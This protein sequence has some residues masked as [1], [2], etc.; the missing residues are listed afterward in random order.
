MEKV[1]L[2]TVPFDV[3]FD[4]FVA[5]QQTIDNNRIDGYFCS[6]DKQYEEDLRRYLADKFAGLTVEDDLRIDVHLSSLQVSMFDNVP[7]GLIAHN[8]LFDFLSN[9]PQ[10]AMAMLATCTAGQQLRKDPLWK[11]CLVQWVRSKRSLRGDAECDAAVAALLHTSH[12][13]AM[14]ALWSDRLTWE[15][16]KRL[17]LD[18]SADEP[19]AAIGGSFALREYML[20]TP[21]LANRLRWRHDDIDVFFV[22]DESLNGSRPSF[23][24]LMSWIV[25]KC[26]T[27]VDTVRRELGMNLQRTH[28]D[29]LKRARPD[30]MQDQVWDSSIESHGESRIGP[31]EMEEGE[32]DV[33]VV[34]EARPVVTLQ[35][36][37]GRISFVMCPGARSVKEVVEN[38]DLT[39][40]GV[41]LAIK[42]QDNGS[43]SD[44]NSSSSSISDSSSSRAK[45]AALT[46]QLIAS[47]AARRDVEAGVI[48]V[49]GKGRFSYKR[50]RKYCARGFSLRTDTGMGLKENGPL[51]PRLFSPFLLNCIASTPLVLWLPNK[52]FGV[53]KVPLYCY[54]PELAGHNEVVTMQIAH[55]L[56]REIRNLRT[57]EELLE[58]FAS[59]D[60]MIGLVRYALAHH[61]IPQSVL[62]FAFLWRPQPAAPKPYTYVVAQHSR[63]IV[64]EII[65][66]VC[67]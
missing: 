52:A 33:Y 38:V 39:V 35:T 57:D 46:T 53:I 42:S 8:I 6:F 25:N 32:N 26:D 47:E 10:S 11:K 13:D 41:Y 28:G 66:H 43:S 30:Q 36:P 21:K 45:C 22:P 16:I 60:Q 17:P 7:R 15:L 31:Y 5:A 63:I 50:I 54:D 59:P 55:W 56:V 20:R 18:H 67:V 34:G 4:K 40:C 23:A 1:P 12:D 19:R 58:L 48:S 44:S 51:C 24:I 37:I 61:V 65:F 3:A 2:F 14:A 62:H 29:R 27:F 64:K 9:D 49:T